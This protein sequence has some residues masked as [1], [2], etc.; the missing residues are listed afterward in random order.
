MLEKL[1][2]KGKIMQIDREGTFR[3]ALV[4]YGISFTTNQFPQFVCRLKASEIWDP[5]DEIWV[6]W[7]PYD[8]NEITGYF[9]LVG[10]KGETLNCIQLEKALPWDGV[11]FAGLNDGDYSDTVVQ[12]RVENRTYE[13]NT[14][15]QVAWIDE[16][17]AVPGNTVKKLD[18]AELK[19]LDA[20]YKNIRK[21][22]VAAKAPAKPTSP[23]TVT[24][25]G[26]KPTADKGM[27]KN[28]GRKQSMPTVPQ[29]PPVDMPEGNCTKEDAWE[30]V[31]GMKKPGVDDKVLSAA[32]LA[33]VKEVGDGKHPDK[34]N[35]QEWFRVRELVLDK[36]AVF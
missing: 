30:A 1:D 19:K 32:W 11:S 5:D 21:K 15:L 33:A 10:A 23:G 22:T 3:G 6:D 17:N 14:T 13:D 8:V 18:A 36:T 25:K 4:D 16:Y 7:T 35:S 26:A 24:K 31:L 28:V 12:F 2:K 27:V 20:A 9:V 34:F 29:E